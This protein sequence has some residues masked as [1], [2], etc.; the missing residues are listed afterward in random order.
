[1]MKSKVCSMEKSQFSWFA[2][3]CQKV[4]TNGGNNDVR[5]FFVPVWNVESAEPNR[6]HKCLTLADS[7]GSA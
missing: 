2:E 3:V 5:E 6:P 4:V 1:M 7:P